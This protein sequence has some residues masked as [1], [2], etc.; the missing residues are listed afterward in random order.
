M[1]DHPRTRRQFEIPEVDEEHTEVTSEADERGLCLPIDHIMS[2]ISGLA[3]VL[4]GEG[5][6]E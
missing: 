4:D 5:E 3:K 1:A 2:K 6:W